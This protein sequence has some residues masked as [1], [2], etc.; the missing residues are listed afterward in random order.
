MYYIVSFIF[1]SGLRVAHVPLQIRVRDQHN[2]KTRCVDACSPVRG[3]RA[4]KC[5]AYV[6]INII[7]V[8]CCVYVIYIYIYMYIERERERER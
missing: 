4:R 2:L 8:A 6:G 7:S 1:L 5:R 3:A